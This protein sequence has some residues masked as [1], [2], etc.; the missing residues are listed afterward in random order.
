MSPRFEKE[1]PEA[2]PSQPRTDERSDG[3]RNACDFP[4]S[5]RLKAP[6]SAP[7]EEKTGLLILLFFCFSHLS[8]EVHRMYSIVLMMALPS[9]A[10]LPADMGH[11][12]VAYRNGG[13]HCNGCYCSGCY[14]CH[15]CY[16]CNCN[17]RDRGRRHRCHGCNCGCYCYGCYCYGG[18]HCSGGCHCYGGCCWPPLLPL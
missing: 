1:C 5:Q 8:Q 13:C 16:G 7:P 10:D 12:H 18:F 4:T 15:G 17:G 2:F 6:Q 9:G 3:F 11:G 14:G